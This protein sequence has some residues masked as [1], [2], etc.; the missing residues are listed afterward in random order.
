[1]YK[2]QEQA[3]RDFEEINGR[4][5]KYSLKATFFSSLTNPTT[6]LMYAAIY[7][8]VAIAGCFTVVGGTLTIGQLTSF[9]SYT[10]QYTCLLYTSR[11]V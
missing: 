6:R 1:M 5:A 2:R 9:L 11:C 8:G 3:C 4:L 10:N 7:A